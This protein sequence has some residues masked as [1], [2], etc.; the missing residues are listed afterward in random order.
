MI[1]VIG[2]DGVDPAVGDGIRMAE[3]IYGGRSRH[4]AAGVCSVLV[5]PRETTSRKR[6]R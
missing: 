6:G 5:V 3:K 1:L 4:P 2:L